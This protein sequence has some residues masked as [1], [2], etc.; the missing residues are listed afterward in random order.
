MRLLVGTQ[1]LRVQDVALLVGP[2]GLD[3]QRQG[4]LAQAVLHVV[5]Q[6]RLLHAGEGT[7]EAFIVVGFAPRPRDVV[8]LFGFALLVLAGR[9]HFAGVVFGHDGV[10]IFG[11]LF[12]TG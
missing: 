7:L 1:L 5:V 2:V 10:L 9:R 4:V 11:A 3:E 8:G 6:V 12:R